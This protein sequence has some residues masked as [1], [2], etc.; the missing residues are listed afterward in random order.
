M[1][2]ASELKKGNVV[3]I[4]N[5]TYVVSHIDV[6]TPSARG[7]VTLY[8]VRFNNVKTKQKYEGSYKGNDMLNDVDLQ[9]KPIAIIAP[10]V[11]HRFCCHP[12]NPGVL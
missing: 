10:C 1:P 2:R 4:N 5:E 7:A 8:K 12:E 11:H 3:E 6:K 9:R